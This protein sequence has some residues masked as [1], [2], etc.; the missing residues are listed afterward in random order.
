VP[1][2]DLALPCQ[3]TRSSFP[4]HLHERLNYFQGDT[5]LSTYQRVAHK[6]L[7]TEK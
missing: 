3:V 4:I 2:G 5:R 6:I 1:R 7:R